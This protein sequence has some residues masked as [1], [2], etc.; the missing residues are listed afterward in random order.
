[1]IKEVSTLA[2]LFILSGFIA[3]MFIPLA[4][5][6]VGVAMSSFAAWKF[7]ARKST[8]SKLSG[9]LLLRSG[10][11]VVAGAVITTT[12]VIAAMSGLFK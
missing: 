3:V 4:P 9:N 12:F 10:L 8:D 5:I 6:I 11:A 2:A 1:M 7:R